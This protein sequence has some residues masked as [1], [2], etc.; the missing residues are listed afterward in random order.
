[1]L[2]RLRLSFPAL[3]S[4]PV[5]NCRVAL[6]QRNMGESAFLPERGRKLQQVKNLRVNYLD[7]S[8]GIMLA[9]NFPAVPHGQGLSKDP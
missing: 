8:D 6:L 9:G 2:A 4:P 1:M 3:S 7:I 5:P